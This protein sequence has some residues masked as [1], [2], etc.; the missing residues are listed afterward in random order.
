MSLLKMKNVEER[1]ILEPRAVGVE[2]MEKVGVHST[3]D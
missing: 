1:R 2:E 3:F